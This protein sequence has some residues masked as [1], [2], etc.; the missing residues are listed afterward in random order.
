MPGTEPTFTVLCDQWIYS[1][2]VF[3]IGPNGVY[4]TLAP[5]AG[6]LQRSAPVP[7]SRGARFRQD[8]LGDKFFLMSVQWGSF[9]ER[10]SPSGSMRGW[11]HFSEEPCTLTATVVWLNFFRPTSPISSKRTHAV[12]AAIDRSYQP[13]GR[14][15][16]TPVLFGSGTGALRAESRSSAQPT[17]SMSTMPDRLVAA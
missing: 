12:A 5:P 17:Q 13:V 1:H 7:P 16:G 9:T 15:K 11:T 3:V 4:L 10:N 2:L 6:C 8:V 14:P